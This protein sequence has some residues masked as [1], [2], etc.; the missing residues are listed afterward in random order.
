MRSGPREASASDEA[1]PVRLLL[2][3]DAFALNGIPYSGFPLILDDRMRL[4]EEPHAFLIHTCLRSGRVRSKATWK[5]YGR[6]LY[7]FFGFVI[8]NGLIWKQYEVAGS[9]HPVE[10]YRDWALAEC[11]LTRRTVNAR[12][13]TILRFYKWA[14]SERLIDRF[15]FDEVIVPVRYSSGM[16]AHTDGSGGLRA[17]SQ[18][19]MRESSEPLRLLTLEQGKKCLAAL[20]NP[21]HHLMFRFAAQTGLRS[22]ELRSFPVKYL[23]DPTRRAEVASKAA[24]RMRLSPAD[25]ALKGD[26]A[27]SIDVPVALLTDLWRYLILERPKRARQATDEPTALFLTGRGAPYSDR[28]IEKVFW[29]LQQRVGFRVTPHMLRHMYATYTLHCLRERGFKGDALLYVRDRLGHA[30]VISTQIYLHLLEQL[31]AALM[32]SHED[33]LS[34]L[35]GGHHAA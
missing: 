35:L 8:A 32:L 18:L 29:R 10:S 31:D 12:L 4:I 22:E 25:M 5:R 33:E 30:S 28:A 34:A 14:A 9:L 23:F 13:R 27:R 17:S 24:Y 6:D 2:A 1:L 7:D 19:L 26:K 15:P 21:T 3:T 20:S 16:L 11:G